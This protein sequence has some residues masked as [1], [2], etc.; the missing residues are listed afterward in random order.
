MIWFTS[1]NFMIINFYWVS[2]IEFVYSSKI[3]NNIEEAPLGIPKASTEEEN[4]L[5]VKTI[6]ESEIWFLFEFDRDSC[7]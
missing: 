7:D 3:L 5:R 4:H 6:A 2:F 1:L